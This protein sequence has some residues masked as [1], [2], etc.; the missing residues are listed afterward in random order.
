MPQR[1]IILDRDGTIIEDTHYPKDPGLVMLLPGA[2]AGLR[3]M[4]ELGYRLFVVSNQSGVGRG[5]I[6]SEEF[7]SVHKKVCELLLAE[8]IAIA[9]FFYCFHKPEDACPCRKPNVG[10][11]PLSHGGEKLEWKQGYVIGDTPADMGLA[12]KIGAQGLLV[13]T[14]KGKETHRAQP[15]RLSFANLLKVADF[16]ADK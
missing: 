10:L 5:I 3:R 1:A 8:R 11:V 14:G 15:H 9:E 4:M 7:W 12:D 16:L 2:I 6:S 13:L